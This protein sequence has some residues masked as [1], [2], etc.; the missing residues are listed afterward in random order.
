MLLN[1]KEV[2]TELKMTEPQVAKVG[3][4][5]Q[6]FMGKMRELFQNG[7]GGGNREEMQAAMAKIQEEQSKAVNEILD[8][9][10]QKRFKQ[11]ELQRAGTMAVLRKDVAD[12]LKIT[13][14]QK[15]KIQEIQRAQFEA[16]RNGGGG[17]RLGPDSTPEERAAAMKARE[18]AQKALNEKIAGVLTDAQKAQW[19]AMQGEPFKFPPMQFGGFGGRRGGGG[20]PPAAPPAA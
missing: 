17:A 19:K 20:N 16:Q 8:T 1:V 11:L 4:K 13:E 12:E 2:Q 15:T 9:K 18:E 7:G 3:E 5:Q 10:Q 14:E 6:E